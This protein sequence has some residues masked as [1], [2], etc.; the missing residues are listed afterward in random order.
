[1]NALVTL[2]YLVLFSS[3]FFRRYVRPSRRGDSKGRSARSRSR[4]PSPSAPKASGGSRGG[5]TRRR[6]VRS[7][8][9]SGPAKGKKAAPRD[10]DA[11]L[12]RA[13]RLSRD[14]SLA[15]LL[16][17]ACA[18]VLGVPY[19]QRRAAGFAA[20]A[21]FAAVHHEYEV[22]YGMANR[23]LD[24]VDIFFARWVTS[25]HPSAFGN[26][27]L[28]AGVVANAARRRCWTSRPSR[29]PR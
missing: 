1:M 25:C 7:Q 9:P 20:A 15:Y 12:L 18:V 10:S 17:S 3:F 26:L 4:S 2:S 24:R 13:R 6:R 16:P 19:W 23:L 14:T 8:S 11:V 29:R 5:G 27:T 22:R 28:T 21:L